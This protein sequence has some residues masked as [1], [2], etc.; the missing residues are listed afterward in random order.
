MYWDDNCT[1]TA[2]SERD[3]AS[4]ATHQR[5][6]IVRFP[7]ISAGKPA[8]VTSSASHHLQTV[9]SDAPIHTGNSPS[10]LSDLATAT[11]NI[12]SRIQLSSASTYR[13]ESLAMQLFL[14]PWN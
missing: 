11:A 8:L 3:C 12:P 10:Y 6:Q 9:C 2:G 5:C 4:S 13:H 14:A 7:D 1:T